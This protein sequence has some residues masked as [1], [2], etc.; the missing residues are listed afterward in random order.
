MRQ[1]LIYILKHNAFIQKMYRVIMSF[2]FKVWGAFLPTDDKLVIFVSFMGMGF[3]DSPKA[4]YDYMQS[5]SEYEG[6]RC[7]WALSIRKNIRI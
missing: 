6:Y 5:H 7:V 1:R 2:V 3:N 4:I